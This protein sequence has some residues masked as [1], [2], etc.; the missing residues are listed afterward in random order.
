M[1]ILEVTTKVFL[2]HIFVVGVAILFAFS[3]SPLLLSEVSIG[4][5]KRGHKSLRENGEVN[6]ISKY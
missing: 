4:A 3:T 6:C 2:C 1:V 5:E